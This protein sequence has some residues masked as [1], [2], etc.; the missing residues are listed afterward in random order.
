MC[1]STAISLA[2]IG[3]PAIGPGK[4]RFGGNIDEQIVD[5]AAPMTASMALRSAGV[6]GR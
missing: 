5:R 3:R 4:P 1:R 2:C 6:R